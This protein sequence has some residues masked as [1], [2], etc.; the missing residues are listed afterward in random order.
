MPHELKEKIEVMAKKDRRSLNAEIVVLLEGIVNNDTC[1][2]ADLIRS[3]IK[4]E[5]SKK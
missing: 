3:I 2:D 5:L 1:P 4:E